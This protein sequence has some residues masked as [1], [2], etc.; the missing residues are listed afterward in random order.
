M[1]G[2]P[3]LRRVAFVTA[4]MAA[5][6]AGCS[7]SGTRWAWWEGGYQGPSLLSVSDTTRREET[8]AAAICVAIA[9]AGSAVIHVTGKAI[10]AIDQWIKRAWQDS[11]PGVPMDSR[12]G[13]AVRVR[14]YPSPP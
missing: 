1:R 8:G 5:L 13:L 6:P 14:G 12:E 9:A 11:Y 7:L 2:R 3:P 10:E 4:A